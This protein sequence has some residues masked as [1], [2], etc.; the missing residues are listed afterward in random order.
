MLSLL[1]SRLSGLPTACEGNNSPRTHVARFDLFKGNL[2]QK[3]I[4]VLH[5]VVFLSLV[6][7]AINMGLPGI[8]AVYVCYISYLG[9]II[10][11]LIFLFH[12]PC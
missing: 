10:M 2:L 5:F 3:E 1:R 8:N 12:G 4:F 6:V 11:A 9:Y 7:I